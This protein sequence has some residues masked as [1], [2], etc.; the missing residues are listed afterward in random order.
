MMENLSIEY[1]IQITTDNIHILMIMI[2]LFL[3]WQSNFLYANKY[4]HK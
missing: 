4:I 2:L 1:V 3:S